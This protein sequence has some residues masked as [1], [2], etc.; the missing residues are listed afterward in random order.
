MNPIDVLWDLL[1]SKLD[2][3][4][5]DYTLLQRRVSTDR[6]IEEILQQIDAAVTER[7]S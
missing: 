1:V 2:A 4:G 5:I 6:T 7:Q 3:N